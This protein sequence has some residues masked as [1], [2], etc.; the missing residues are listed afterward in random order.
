MILIALGANLPS[1]VGAPEQ[2]L[3]AVLLRLQ[4]DN[5][6]V[7][8]RSSWWESEALPP[9]GRPA[10]RQPRFV[11]GVAAVA[12]LLPPPVLLA[13]L[14][15]IEAAFGRM[16]RQRWDA[17][18][19]DLDLIDHDGRIG[20][21]DGVVLPHPGLALRAFVLH[22]LAEVAPGWRHPVTG[23]SVAHLIAALPPQQKAWRFKPA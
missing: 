7:I 13:H 10:D 14:H 20:D 17:R 2:T 12:T 19:C 3:D 1:P 21:G 5:I 8:A 4:A 9:E 15:A 23:H 11:N 6:R 16:R 22:P 18:P